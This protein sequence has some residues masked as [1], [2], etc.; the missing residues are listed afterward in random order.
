MM[1]LSSLA[2]A[3]YSALAIEFR[4]V[5]F[6]FTHTCFTLIDSTMKEFDRLSNCMHDMSL[7]KLRAMSAKAFSNITAFVSGA[8][9]NLCVDGIGHG[10]DHSS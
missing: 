10:L 4:G 6:H 1:R 3:A 9:G 5:E 7:V 8:F 2:V